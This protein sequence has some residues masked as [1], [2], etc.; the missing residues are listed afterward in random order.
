MTKKE[1]NNQERSPIVAVMGHIDHGKSTLLDYI[2][3]SSTVDKEAGGITQHL[4][5]YEVVHKTEAGAEKNITF[6]DT[7]GHEAFSKMRSRGAEVADIVIL[8]VAA[9]DGVKVQTLE[10]LKTIE[11]AK[12][13][14]IVAI[15]KIDKPNANVE[16]VKVDLAAAGVYLEGFGGNVPFAPISAKTGAGVS[17]LLDVMLLIAEMGELKID[18]TKDAEGFVIESNLDPKKGGSATIILRDGVLKKGTFLVIGKNITPV[19]YMEN[20]MGQSVDEAQAPSPIK[21]IGFGEVVPAGAKFRSVGSK[22]EAEK[23]AKEAEQ[24]ELSKK[25]ESRFENA[26]V[27]VPVVLK[28]DV[29]GSLEAI[30][31]ELLKL[32]TTEAKIKFIIKGV[33][34]IS[35]NDIKTASGSLRPLIIGFNV[36][37]DNTAKDMAEN[38]NLTPRIFNIIYDISPIIVKEMKERTPKIEVEETVGKAKILKIFSK[39]KDRQIV[40]GAVLEGSLMLG[41]KCKVLRQLN[42]IGRGTIVDLQQQ[43]QKADEVVKGNQFGALIESKITI[44]IDDTIE[45]FDVV[46]K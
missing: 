14:Y 42:E 27:V 18:T 37:I 9:D 10:A 4:G 20:S 13:P 7:P 31:K 34:N 26:R 22:K 21:V 11:Q 28:A 39:T 24:K 46:Q 35:E 38:L 41:R 32:E 8:V 5:A 17:E 36:K 2:R 43:K 45:V 33:G 6:L 40:G 15:N 25:D 44:A 16:K 1:T 3:K 12:V 29:S 30:E 19:R 23:L